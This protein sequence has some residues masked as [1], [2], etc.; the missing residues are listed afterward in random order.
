MPGVGELLNR[1]VAEERIATLNWP[2]YP[3]TPEVGFRMAHTGDELWLEFRVREAATQGLETRTHGEVYKDSCVEFF[4]SFDKAN[5]YNLEVNCIGTVHLGYGPSRQER[6][7]VSPEALSCLGVRTSLG[8]TPFAERPMGEW[9]LTLR[10][11]AGLFAFDTLEGFGGRVAAANLYKIGD[12]LSKPHYLSWVPI[13][14]PRP[15]YHRP[16]FFRGIV[17][18]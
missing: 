1:Y 8:T 13:E 5:Y 7:F 17:F 12:N 2:E 6:Q 11:S 3:Y 15:D 9:R 14:T 10:M 18:G 16:E 4:V